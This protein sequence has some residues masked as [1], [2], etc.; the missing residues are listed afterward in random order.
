MVRF[1]CWEICGPRRGC[2]VRRGEDLLAKQHASGDDETG[3]AMGIDDETDIENLKARPSKVDSML[4][5]NLLHWEM[6]ISS[7]RERETELLDLPEESA[8]ILPIL[9]ELRDNPESFLAA[10]SYSSSIRELATKRCIIFSAQS[11][12]GLPRETQKQRDDKGATATTTRVAKSR[13]SDPLINNSMLPRLGDPAA[14][15]TAHVSNAQPI[16]ESRQRTRSR[17]GSR[18]GRGSFTD[19]ISQTWAE[20]LSQ[21]VPAQGSFQLA[22]KGKQASLPSIRPKWPQYLPDAWY[23]VVKIGRLGRRQRRL[24]KLTE[25]HVLSV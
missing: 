14:R 24:L 25:Y 16:V 13:P 11:R 10:G 7:Y 21:V 22:P 3:I 9:T 19:S 23:E 15:L 8:K 6:A 1:F 20:R 12:L 17:V 2:C 5:D 4:E 18:A